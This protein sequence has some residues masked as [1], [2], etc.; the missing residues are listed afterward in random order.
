MREIGFVSGHIEINGAPM[1]EF[2]SPG[3]L[4]LIDGGRIGITGSLYKSFSLS[5]NLVSWV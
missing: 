1:P 5:P 4:A 3:L 2:A